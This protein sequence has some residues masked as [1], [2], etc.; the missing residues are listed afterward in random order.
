MP[1]PSGPC[2]GRRGS[3]YITDEPQHTTNITNAP[4]T[5]S[6]SLI[7][8]ASTYFA[9]WKALRPPLDSV[10]IRS[11]HHNPATMS[12]GEVLKAD[13]DFTKETDAAIPEAEKLGEVCLMAFEADR[14]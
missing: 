4:S 5:T 8:R 6:T 2:G 14:S 10:Q 3:L 13:K 7:E 9:V 12:S 11:T 1:S